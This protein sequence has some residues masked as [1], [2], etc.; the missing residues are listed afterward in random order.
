MIKNKKSKKGF[1]PRS[2]HNDRYSFKDLIK[3]YPA[4]APFTFKS[5]F[6]DISIDFADPQAVV[7]LNQAL[8]IHFYKIENWTLRRGNLCP[9]IPGRADYIHH[10]ADLLA[11]SNSE[12][13]P[14]GNN[15]RGLDIGVGANCIYPILG[16]TIYNWSFVGTDI[17]KKA[18]T[19]AKQIIDSNP[20]LRTQVIL[21]H[22]KDPSQIFNK[23][24]LNN[25]KFAF[26]MCNPPFHSSAQ[27]A[28]EAALAKVNNLSD[29]DVSNK[30]LSLNF[31][32]TDSE[33]W[34]PGGEVGFIK[35]M[36]KQSAA[37][38]DNCLWY[39]S[40]VSKKENLPGIYARLKNVDAQDVQTIELKQGNKIS[41]IV[42]WSYLSPKKQKKW[43]L[44]K[45][46]TT[47][48]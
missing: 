10:I 40:L 4:L 23:V 20:S 44:S 5:E 35:L 29:K 41:R 19:Y 45:E 24:I 37:I 6:N 21:R 33:L 9:P 3:S 48:S 39:T 25:E 26:T 34:C 38:K 27:M 1:H 47:K 32:G 28:Q 31:G 22:Q 30:D 18:L 11:K 36:I 14:T 15:I 2:L 7:A 42:A 16:S 13:V 12:G 46:Q 8:L 17:D 43:W